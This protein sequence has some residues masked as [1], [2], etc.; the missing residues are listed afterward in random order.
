MLVRRWEFFVSCN[1]VPRD[2]GE[3]SPWDADVATWDGLSRGRRD[4]ERGT[5]AIQVIPKP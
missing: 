1:S 2:A 5:L 3:C 4:G